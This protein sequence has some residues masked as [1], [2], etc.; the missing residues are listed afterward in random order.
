MSIQRYFV[1]MKL[2]CPILFYQDEPEDLQVN[3]PGQA[4]KQDISQSSQISNLEISRISSKT[5]IAATKSSRIGSRT[6]VIVKSRSK[7]NILR[8]NSSISSK[9][10]NSKEKVNKV[11]KVGRYNSDVR[12][13][14]KN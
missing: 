8:P 3:I 10:Q 9:R 14:F 2:N 12:I 13:A 1:C 7:T 6:D 4:M 5:N 11:S